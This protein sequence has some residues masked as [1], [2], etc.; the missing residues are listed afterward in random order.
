MDDMRPLLWKTADYGKSWRALGASL[1]KDG[2]LHAVREDPKTKGLLF[3][4]TEKG[5]VFS[6]D[7]GL[8][9]R[10]LKLNLPTVAVHDLV[11]KDDDLVLATHG[12]SIF[13]LD[14]I[15][16]LREW[17]K[18]IE[19][20]PVHLFTA[21]PA[22]GWQLEARV[23]GQGKGPGE[24]PPAGARIHY[25][26]RD[27]PKGELTLEIL[28]GKGAVVR[29]LRSRKAEEL[30]PEDDPDPEPREPKPLPKEAGLERAFWDLRY[31]GA[32][33]IRPAKID[34]G[35]PGKGPMV[36][37]GSYTLRLSVDGQSSTTPVEVR[38]DPRVDVPRADLE[39]QLAFSLALRDRPR[40]ALGPR[41]G[42]VAHGIAARPARRRAPGRGGGRARG[43]V[44]RARGGA[45]QPEG[46]GELRHPGDAGRGEALLAPGAALQL[47]E[48]RRRRADAGDAR[49][50]RGAEAGAR[51][52]LRRVEGDACDRRPG[53]QRQGPRARPGVRR[54][55]RSMKC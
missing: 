44:R 16:P 7:D 14:D 48:R 45:A 32:T 51:A 31:E 36:L 3:A 27:E 35:D 23:A 55:A 28:D 30:T 21:R 20:M 11:V 40:A 39:Q 47:G 50:L 29:T 26:L 22:T 4:G 12:R 54:A 46:R 38:L 15:T 19:A 49:G 9:W 41:A 24:N 5:V 52:S 2:Y 37:P 18:Q 42:A 6:K 34:S 17:S 53:A 8:T 25:W 1:P 33:R 13:I 43:E 10:E